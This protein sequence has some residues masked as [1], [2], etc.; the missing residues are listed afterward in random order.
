MVKARNPSIRGG[1]RLEFSS[2][3]RNARLAELTLVYIGPGRAAEKG[4]S[5]TF[6]V[7]M[8]PPSRFRGALRPRPSNQHPL[9]VG[10]S[11]RSSFNPQ[12]SIRADWGPPLRWA[13]STLAFPRST[14]LPLCRRR[15]CAQTVL[16]TTPA[17]HE[18]QVHYDGMTKDET[19]P[20]F[21]YTVGGCLPFRSSAKV[22][23]MQHPTPDQ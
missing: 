8:K 3:C 17:S 23:I 16:R 12:D 6:K 9:V 10:M 1:K 15:I 22:I 11:R 5:G 21:V 20:I 14:T 13:C 18:A 4:K 19:H 2:S 7:R